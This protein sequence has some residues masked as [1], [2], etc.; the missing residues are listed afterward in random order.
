MSFLLKTNRLLANLAAQCAWLMTAGETS[1]DTGLTAEGAAPP[2]GAVPGLREI[3]RRPLPH[4]DG[5]AAT[6]WSTRFLMAGW[7]RRFLGAE[8]L[9]HVAAAHDPFILAANHSTRIEALLVPAFL[10]FHRGGRHVH[11]LADWN[12]LLIPGIGFL[13]RRG[14]VIVVVRKP[15]RPRVLNRLQPL[16]IPPVAPFARARQILEGGG[17]VGIFPEGTTNRDPRRLLAGHSGA[18]RLSLETGVPII[19]LGIRHPEHQ[20]L[21]PIRDSEKMRLMFGG[22]MRPP[23]RCAEGQAP[24]GDVREWHGRIMSEIG[25]LCG[26]RW[27]PKSPRARYAA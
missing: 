16:F 23:G 14:Q 3:L 11:F 13:M 2:G 10:M 8:G 27:E 22:P 5:D 21:H 26:K 1:A 15:A 6:R 7:R 25:R 20:G 17:A 9:E 19:P 12:F 4:L 24:V 18:A